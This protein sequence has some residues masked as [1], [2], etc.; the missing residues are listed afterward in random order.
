MD[1]LDEIVAFVEGHTSLPT[2]VL[3]T[4]ESHALEA[5][6]EE[7][8]AIR[9]YTDVGNLMLYILQQD[10]SSIAA[11]V[12]V[13]DALSQFL[14]IKGRP[15]TIDTSRLRLYEA[16]LACTPAWLRP[17]EFFM[18][19]IAERAEGIPDRKALVTM[20]KTEIAASFRFSRKPPKWLQSPDW[21]CVENRPLL[22]V[23]QI[24]LGDLM[25]DTAQVYLFFD[26]VTAEVRT[27]IQVA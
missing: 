17:P 25:H 7:D 5:V 2:F 16:V 6:L 3:R 22:F 20:V 4:Q 12:S 15:H 8:V 14:Q 24:E 21:I 27:L 10:W 11:Q 26:D 9:P 19:R 23:G 18:D 1:P 13:Q